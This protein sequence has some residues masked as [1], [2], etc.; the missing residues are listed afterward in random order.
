MARIGGRSTAF[1][2]PVAILCAAVVGGLVW[3]ALP[4]VPVGI[5]WVG[6]AL[7]GPTSAPAAG[8]AN[9]SSVTAPAEVGACRAIYTDAL[10]QE[11][12]QRTGGAPTQ[13]AA[14]PAT[15]ATSLVTA[16]APSVRATCT[17]KGAQLGGIVTTVADVSP[18]SIGVARAAFQSQG[19]SCSGY[20]DGIRCTKTS[21]DTTEDQAIRGGVWLST[22]FTAWQ[23]QQYTERIAPQLWPR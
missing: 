10:W 2:V 7:R 9:G 8:A 19:F 23:P 3:L 12:E 20:G 14:P 22:V 17:W 18:A 1:A 15:S 21:G 6:D 4:A 13:D 11:L 5:A 16:L